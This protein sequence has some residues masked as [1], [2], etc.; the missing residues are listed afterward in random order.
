MAQRRTQRR[1]ATVEQ[2]RPSTSRRGTRETA[3]RTRLPPSERTGPENT[4]AF[5]AELLGEDV[6]MTRVMSL[7]NGVVGVLHAAALGIHAIGRGLADALDL[8]PKHAVKQVDRLL[9]NSGLKIWDWFRVGGYLYPKEDAA[10]LAQVDVPLVNR[11]LYA[12][13]PARAQDGRQRQ[14]DA[15]EHPRA[16]RHLR[17]PRPRQ[18]QDRDVLLRPNGARH[19]HHGEPLPEAGADHRETRSRASD[20]PLNDALPELVGAEKRRVGR[21]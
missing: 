5:V 17:H 18:R 3:R 2:R 13:S 11:M 6:H 4:H 20:S 10:L 19:V 7:A 12:S 15:D 9:S 14:A 1:K 21:A 8:D 16:A